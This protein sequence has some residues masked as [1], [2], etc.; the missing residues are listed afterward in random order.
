MSTANGINNKGQ[1]VG[2]VQTPYGDPTQAW[3]FIYWNGQLRRL[4]TPSGDGSVAYA[5]NDAGM[6]VGRLIVPAHGAVPTQSIPVEWRGN[7]FTR[8]L[9]ELTAQ[10]GPAAA[11]A[12]NARGDIA[13]YALESAD[14]DAGAVEFGEYVVNGHAFVD[15]ADFYAIN[16]KGQVLGI[17]NTGDQRVYSNGR[18]LPAFDPSLQPE[19]PSVSAL[20]NAGEFVASIQSRN[21]SSVYDGSYH[22]LALLG[23]QLI[24]PNFALINGGGW[25]V[26]TAKG[27]NDRGWIAA[28]G[29][30]PAGEFHA[31][32]LVPDTAEN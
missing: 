30:T 21:Y 10:V 9:T 3:A 32:L 27:V 14:L 16:D 23:G 22:A 8:V 20:D 7:S 28:N 31:I 26:G 19:F 24:D 25:S 13:G 11:A 4:P 6:A 2:Y 15:H 29:T 12:I 1:V 18:S 17:T 5:I